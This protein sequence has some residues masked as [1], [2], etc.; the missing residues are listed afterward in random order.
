MSVFSSSGISACACLYFSPVGNFLRL[1]LPSSS[2]LRAASHFAGVGGGMAIQCTMHS[3]RKHAGGKGYKKIS[4][5]E[6]ILDSP[7]PFC[8]ALSFPVPSIPMP[9][10][11]FFIYA[12]LEP[13]A[14]LAAP[15]A[16]CCCSIVAA[17]VACCCLCLCSFC[18]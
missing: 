3:A 17:A 2:F 16:C 5:P 18:F 11:P 8:L 1:C 13:P 12:P 6:K 7:P 14:P 9:A 10:H 4:R 15:L